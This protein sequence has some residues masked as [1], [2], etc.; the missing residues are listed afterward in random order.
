M[1]ND[2]RDAGRSMPRCHGPWPLIAVLGFATAGFT[3]ARSDEPTRGPDVLGPT[4]QIRNGTFRGSGTIITSRN[5]ETLILT[6][7]HV[8][9]DAS[10]LKV[11]LHRHNLG[12]F[13]TTGLTEG[14]GWPRLVPTV[15]VGFDEPADVAVLRVRGM[16]ALPHVARFDPRA[17][18]PAQGE[19][20]TSVGIDRT[21]FLTRWRTTA[22]QSGLLDIKRGGGPRRF[23][24]TSKFPEHGRS[25]GGLFRRDGTIVGVCTGQLTVQTGRPK[26]GLFASVE[27]IRGLL[28]DHGVEPAESPV[29]DRPK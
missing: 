5:G 22:L 2:P 14:G 28:K 16:V 9:K 6:A 25:G 21:L 26:M 23:T 18:E 29:A 17:S 12:S 19:E 3:L 11:E 7:A 4:V 15:V 20:L 1:T 13:R 27:S 24:T 8:V 10:D